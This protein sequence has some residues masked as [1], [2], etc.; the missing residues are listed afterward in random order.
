[1]SHGGKVIKQVLSQYLELVQTT[2]K[3]LSRY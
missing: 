3:H 1:L 2:A